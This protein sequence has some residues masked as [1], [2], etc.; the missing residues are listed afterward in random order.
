MAD[1]LPLNVNARVDDESIADPL[2]LRAIAAE[3]IVTAVPEKAFERRTRTCRPP[4]DVRTIIRT[5]WLLIDGRFGGI[6]NRRPGNW[7]GRCRRRCWCRRGRRGRRIGPASTGSEP[8]STDERLRGGPGCDP[9]LGRG[10][11][12]RGVIATRKQG[13]ED[14][15][16]TAAALGRLKPFMMFA[17]PQVYRQVR[18]E[19]DAND[20]QTSQA[21]LKHREAAFGVIVSF[22]IHPERHELANATASSRDMLARLGDSMRADCIVQGSRFS[23]QGSA[24]EVQRAAFGSWFRHR[25]LNGEPRTLNA[26]P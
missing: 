4:T 10:L 23:V 9:T 15:A 25:T 13:C 1:G 20:Y 5:V 18:P 19:P 2:L 7:C 21:T 6:G 17:D 8:C 22:R 12:L 24:F 3:P 26:E 14:A 16:A 11:R